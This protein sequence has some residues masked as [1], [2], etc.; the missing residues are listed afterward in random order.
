MRLPTPSR[1]AITTPLSLFASVSSS[2]WSTLSSYV[3][4]S[5]IL[6]PSIVI[7]IF[8]YSLSNYIYGILFSIAGG[9][10]RFYFSHFFN[11]KTFPYGTFFA[12]LVATILCSCLYVYSIVDDFLV[13]IISVLFIN[14][15]C[16]SLSTMSTFVKETLD[17]KRQSW[18]LYI[19][20]FYGSLLL[21]FICSY[22][23][24]YL[25]L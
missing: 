21:S 17:M 10:T 14:A 1:K 25:C 19:L 20:Y 8:V 13:S 7:H 23:F 22:L 16:G 2:Y 11:T 6:P 4:H 12:N 5:M 24:L 9:L 15:Y 18:L 3:R